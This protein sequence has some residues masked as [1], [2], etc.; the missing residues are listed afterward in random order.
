MQVGL[1]PKQLQNPPFLTQ[2]CLNWLGAGLSNLCPTVTCI[3]ERLI[4]LVVSYLQC[5]VRLA[6]QADHASPWCMFLNINGHCH[7]CH[8]I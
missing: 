8:E 4:M 5:P 6:E 3:L 2:H 1:D 7:E